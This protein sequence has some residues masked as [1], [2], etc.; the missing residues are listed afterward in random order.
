MTYQHIQI[1]N[2][3]ERITI[4]VDSSLNSPYNPIIPY[5]SNDGTGIDIIPV[6]AR[7]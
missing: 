3:G 7:L 5:I 6:M 2:D 1:P 4:N